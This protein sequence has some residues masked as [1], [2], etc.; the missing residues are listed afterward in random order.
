MKQSQH[1]KYLNIIEKLKTS[2]QRLLRELIEANKRFEGKLSNLSDLYL[3]E[4]EILSAIDNFH[5][6]CKR[7]IYLNNVY[8][9][10]IEQQLSKLH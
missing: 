8:K 9:Y 2:E 1:D 10:Y 6:E 4:A 3:Y 7:Y 5:V